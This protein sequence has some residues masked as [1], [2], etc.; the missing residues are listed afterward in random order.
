ME[1]TISDVGLVGCLLG[2]VRSGGFTG[3]R[4]EDL[5]FGM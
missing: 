5:G 1:T 4:A 2:S 3:F